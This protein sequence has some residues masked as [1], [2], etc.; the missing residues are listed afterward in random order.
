MCGRATQSG[1]SCCPARIARWRRSEGRP[2]GRVREVRDG[3]TGPGD[4]PALCPGGADRAQ[5]GTGLAQWREWHRQGAGRPG[6]APAQ[7]PGRRPLRPGE[8][9]RRPPRAHRERAL[10][11]REGRLHRRPAAAAGEVRAG[12]GRHLVPRRGGGHAPGDAGQAVASASRRRVR[13]GGRHRDPPGGC[14]GGGGHQPG[15]GRG[16]GSGTLPGGPLLPAGSGADPHAAAPRAP[17]GPA[18]PHRRLPP[19]GLQPERSTAAA[20]VSGSRGRA[21]RARLSRQR[22]HGRVHHRRRPRRIRRVLLP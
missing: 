1:L 8:L 13:A 18:R 14:A 7:P 19:G 5:R 15:P 2:P 17:G 9:R 12:L 22:P 6:A 21:L 3:G 11:P 20:T 16:G 4:A 10:R